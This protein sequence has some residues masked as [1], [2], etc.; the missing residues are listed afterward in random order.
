MENGRGDHHVAEYC[1]NNTK[2]A[3]L[4]SE[5][6]EHGLFYDIFIKSIDH[7]A[8][9][10]IYVTEGTNAEVDNN[11]K[12]L[13]YNARGRLTG[14]IEHLENLGGVLVD[15]SSNTIYAST[16]H[17][18]TTRDASAGG[19]LVAHWTSAL[20]VIS[21]KPPAI[22]K[23]IRFPK[24][25]GRYLVDTRGRLYYYD[26]VATKIVVL[27]PETERVL[28]TISVPVADMAIGP[29]DKIFTVNDFGQIN[30]YDHFRFVRTFGGHFNDSRKAI[31]V[32]PDGNIYVTNGDSGKVEIYRPGDVKPIAVIEGLR[33]A[34]PVYFDQDSNVYVPCRFGVFTDHPGKPGIYVYKSGTTRL[35]RT[36]LSSEAI[37]G[38]T[39]IPGKRVSSCCKITAMTTPNRLSGVPFPRRRH[40]VPAN[41]AETAVLASSRFKGLV[42][43][44]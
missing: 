18:E 25:R 17:E 29:D 16:P 24:A 37:F 38:V 6:M 15:R 12:I 27:D 26:R 14:K 40:D 42:E 1:G 43:T 22:I 2:A 36:Y 4:I 7:D 31:A 13:V 35:L 10:N 19:V 11:G 8:D 41:D 32:A 20:T 5:G 21:G 34:G 30:A 44:P 23:T 39:L 3:G 28:N 33:Y 9:G